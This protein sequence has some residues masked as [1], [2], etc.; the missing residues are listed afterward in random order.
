MKH[1]EILLTSL[2]LLFFTGLSF[3][4][5]CQEN[6]YEYCIIVYDSLENATQPLSEWKEEKGLSTFTAVIGWIENTY[7]GR[8]RS[9][10]IRNFLAEKDTMWTDLKYIL[11]AGGDETIPP[12]Y[13][14]TDYFSYVNVPSDD[15]FTLL[16]TNWDLDNDSIWGED[17]TDCA[18]D[19]DEI[20]FGN[21]RYYIGRLPSD[22]VKDLTNMVNK[23]VA[24]EKNQSVEEWKNT[25]IFC[26]GIMDVADSI[27][28]SWNL[29]SVYSNQFPS[30]NSFIIKRLY[31]SIRNDYD[32]LTVDNFMNTYNQGAVIVNLLSHGGWDSYYW[33][34]KYGSNWL[35]GDYITTDHTDSVMN[36]DKLPLFVSCACGSAWYDKSQ[37]CIGESLMTAPLGGCIIFVGSTR[38]DL[39][40]EY[41]FFEDFFGIADQRAGI[42]W[43]YAKIKTLIEWGASEDEYWRFHYLQAILLGDP[44]LRI[45]IPSLYIEENPVNEIGELYIYPNPAHSY[46]YCK[47]QEFG[48]NT[49]LTIYDMYGREREAITCHGAKDYMLI[50]VED[51]PPGMYFVMLK[52]EIE[53]LGQGKFVIK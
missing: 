27:E 26:G 1:P 10:K 41:F 46:I 51:Y 8:D 28:T 48:N 25:I 2:F 29:E 50:N 39:P 22:N 13:V 36:G 17:S 53:T 40:Q 20:D 23:I 43:Q 11:L 32:S 24:Y 44:E 14:R 15:Y 47:T 12:R 9:E 45:N 38:Y 31:E 49:S 52:N 37:K 16:G 19:I 3:D 33:F 18:L 5:T 4:S 6:G 21:Y 30:P 42:A 7:S 34:K 35:L